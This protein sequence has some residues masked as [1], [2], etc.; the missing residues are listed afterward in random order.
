MAHRPG[1]QRGRKS[2]VNIFL[3]FCEKARLHYKRINYYHVC[4]FIEHLANVPYT[5][6]SIS[7]TVSHMRTFYKISGLNDAAWHHYKVGLAMRAVATNIRHVPDP[8]QPVTPAILRA[9]LKHAHTLPRAKAMRLAILLMYM[10]FLRQSSIAP[11]T[12]AGFDSTRHLTPADITVTSQGLSVKVKW[13]K[14]MQRSSDAKTLLLP[15]TRD[16]LLCPVRAYHQYLAAAAPKEAGP[17]LVHPDG[18]PLTTRYISGQWTALLL[19]AGVA[20]LPFSLH[21][22]RRGAAGYTYNDQKADLNDVM[23]QGTWRS[24]AVREYIQ[25]Q[26]GKL[27]TVHEALQRL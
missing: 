23:T 2:A 5:P 18:R 25:P 12:V 17:L 20:P 19:K 1:T 9:A 11:Y 10:G 13:T 21:S 24:L 15:E 14:T 4:W 3:L 16:A 8:K 6:G 27:N 26:E 7:N 22:L